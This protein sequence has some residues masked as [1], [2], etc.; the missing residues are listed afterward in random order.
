[1][2]LRLKTI[3]LCLFLVSCH[4]ASGQSSFKRAGDFYALQVGNDLVTA[5][6]FTEVSDFYEG[7][8]WV[9][10]GSLYGYIDTLGVSIT[11]FVYADVDRFIDGYAAVSRDTQD[12]LYG[13]VNEVGREVCDLKYN[14]IK[15]FENGFAAVQLDS[16][17]TLIDTSGS[18][19]MMPIFDYAPK[20]ISDQFVI[21]VRA[22]KWGVI[23]TADRLKYPF[24]YDLITADG[25][26]YLA[27]KKVY[28][29]LL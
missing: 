29:G 12:G 18:E 2:W 9:N 27:N 26:A 21:A 10:K 4:F 23:D 14:R 24:V 8:A 6:V 25:V 20:V 19:L 1:M 5:Y 16:N 15:P 3:T 11:D 17:W 7:K 13:F 22:N 28:L